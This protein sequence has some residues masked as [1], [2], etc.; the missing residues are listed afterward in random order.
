MPKIN[1]ELTIPESIPNNTNTTEPKTPTQKHISVMH[2]AAKIEFEKRKQRKKEKTYSPPSY[3]FITNTMLFIATIGISLG[4][5]LIIMSYLND[6]IVTELISGL[7][8]IFAF[9]IY[10][11]VF[12]GR[13]T[14]GMH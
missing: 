8:I 14:G 13:Y 3:N 11:I 9:V 1:D 10:R 12:G 5:S 6:T 7:L 4:I 2:T